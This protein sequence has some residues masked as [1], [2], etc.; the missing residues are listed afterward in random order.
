MN[1]FK[2]KDWFIIIPITKVKE[3]D[4][5]LLEKEFV[6]FVK[7]F[8]F[9]KFK[10]VNYYEPY[11]NKLGTTFVIFGSAKMKKNSKG[12]NRLNRNVVIFL[13]ELYSSMEGHNEVTKT[14]FNKK[15]IVKETE[16][17]IYKVKNY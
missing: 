15:K 11:T 5:F 4:K 12:Y 1:L 7:R 2:R 3:N 16:V 6:S 17:A 9:W 13:L 8:F 10:K 14:F